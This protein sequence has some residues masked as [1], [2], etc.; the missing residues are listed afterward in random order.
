MKKIFSL[1]VVLF[2]ATSLVSA[3]MN[4]KQVWKEAKKTAKIMEKQGWILKSP[5]SLEMVLYSYMDSMNGGKYC[6]VVNEATAPMISIAENQAMIYAM[7]S[8]V[9]QTVAIVAESGRQQLSPNARYSVDNLNY[10]LRHS[11]T[12][13]KHEQGGHTTCR[14]YFLLD[15]EAAKRCNVVAVSE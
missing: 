12:I 13:L 5:G 3:Q 15:K 14:V 4:D 10:A 9:Q 6:S 2:C 1:L 7:E 8:A 11:F